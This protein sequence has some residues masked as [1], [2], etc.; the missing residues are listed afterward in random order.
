MSLVLSSSD[1]ER[2]RATQEVLLTPL[3]RPEPDGWIASSAAAVL[4]LLEAAHVTVLASGPELLHTTLP[5]RVQRDFMGYYAARDPAT[6]R[7][8][9]RGLGVAHL[10]DVVRPE[11]YLASELHHDFAVPN[12]LFDAMLLRARSGRGRSLWMAVQYEKALQPGEIEHRRAL[13]GLVLPAFS[14]GVTVFE[15]TGVRPVGPGGELD[16][17][18]TAILL[19]GT[20]GRALH[21]NAALAR[22]LANDPHGAAL[23]EEMLAM[24]AA[25][26]AGRGGID[27][28]IAGGEMVRLSDT[29][30]ARYRLTA[31][32]AGRLAP[33]AAIVHATSISTAGHG[34]ESL[35]HRFGLTPREAQVAR[36]LAE[37]LTNREI[38]AALAI[39]EH[40]A[41]R[42]TERVLQKMSLR[43][44]GD[45]RGV[46]TSG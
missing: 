33:G 12:S 43:S 2:V 20:G 1:L 41:E 26:L 42:H 13:L 8:L 40:T 46:L 16:A 15:Q 18:P 21:R 6:P 39:S 37:R 11:E 14:A 3:A 44:R 32:P 35:R 9:E 38:A 25:L 24:G 5:E 7:A 17:L 30:S 28:P 29:A 36:L 19:V 27:A 22:L 10:Y 4:G 34:A 31:A 23:L 45:V